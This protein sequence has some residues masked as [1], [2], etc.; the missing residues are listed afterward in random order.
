MLGKSVTLI[1]DW[2]ISINITLPSKPAINEADVVIMV[3]CRLDNQMNFG[4]PPFIQPGTKLDCVN[5]SHEELTIILVPI[6]VVIDPT[7]FLEALASWI[8]AGMIGL[9]CRN[10]AA[11]GDQF[12]NGRTI[13]RKQKPIWLRG[14][15]ASTSACT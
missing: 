10:H 5:G 4:N 2:Q 11:R 6:S 12:G 1:W 3:Y 14:A 15:N 7:A 8:I 13:L 9:T